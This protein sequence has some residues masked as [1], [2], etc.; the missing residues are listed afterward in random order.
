MS[1]TK[2]ENS[3]ITAETTE[4]LEPE[5]LKKNKINTEVSTTINPSLT[6]P[7]AVVP[8]IEEK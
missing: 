5:L 2:E 1:V 6:E 8:A 7:V 3:L 4:G